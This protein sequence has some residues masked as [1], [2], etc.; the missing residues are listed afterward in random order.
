MHICITSILKISMVQ[1]QDGYIKL[2]DIKNEKMDTEDHETLYKLFT[3]IGHKI[4][5]SNS[6]NLMSVYFRK[7][8]T[9]SK[10]T[11]MPL[12]IRSMYQDLINQRNNS[13]E[14]NDSLR[15]S[16]Q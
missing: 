6:K 14:Y 9:M 1:N 16:K 2:N 5:N 12:R 7:I 4:D 10:N 8:S 15:L 13:W 11:S 3:D